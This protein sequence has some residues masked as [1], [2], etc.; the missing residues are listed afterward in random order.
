[1]NKK[2]K[3]I[4]FIKRNLL[5]FG[6]HR[7]IP[8]QLFVKLGYIGSMSHWIENHRNIGYSNFP[9]KGFNSKLREGLYH[10]IIE[11]QQLNEKIDYLEFGVARGTSFK[12]WIN[13]IQHKEARFFG[14]DTFTGLPEDWGHF[15]K[16]DMSSNNEIPKID[17]KRHQFYQGLFQAT[18]PKFLEQYQGNRRKV[19]HLDADLFSST[20]FVLT[21]LSPYIKS[22]DILLFDE[23]NVPLDEFKAFKV[24][25]DSYYIKYT[26]L[27]EANNYYQ[28]A[29]LIL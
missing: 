4:R 21:S 25:V 16:G 14:F 27:G 7:I 22:G 2:L 6:V 1:M 8:A 9:F 24:W 18:L 5:R 20:L 10:H 23:F 12:W 28:T 13:H 11:D 17:D 3:I 26:V 15:K 29:I 19:I